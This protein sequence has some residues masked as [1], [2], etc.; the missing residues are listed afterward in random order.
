MNSLIRFEDGHPTALIEFEYDELRN[1]KDAVDAL[2]STSLLRELRK[3]IAVAI[4]ELEDAFDAHDCRAE[5]SEYGICRVCGRV[6]G[7]TPAYRDL[8]GGE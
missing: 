4:L 7:D 2:P 1:L 8:Y 3:N 6:L 5:A